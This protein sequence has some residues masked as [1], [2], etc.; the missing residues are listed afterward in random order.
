MLQRRVTRGG[1][2]KGYPGGG[3]KT[4]SQAVSSLVREG[5]SLCLAVARPLAGFARGYRDLPSVDACHCAR[6]KK[7]RALM[8]PL[9]SPESL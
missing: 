2:F 9:I 8:A 6:P 1:F 3:R 7:S 5:P 4:P